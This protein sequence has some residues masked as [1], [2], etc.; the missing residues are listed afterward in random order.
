MDNVCLIITKSNK[1]R[2]GIKE[3]YPNHGVMLVA[4][5]GRGVGSSRM[6]SKQCSFMDRKASPYMPFI[7]VL[8]NCRNQRVSQFF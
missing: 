7:N 2:F 1:K 8:S 4:E 5:K 3:K 6:G